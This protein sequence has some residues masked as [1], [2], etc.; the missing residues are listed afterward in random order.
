VK[1]R[2]KLDSNHC[3]IVKAYQ[4]LGCSVANTAKA[5][6]GVPDL[7]VGCMGLTDPVEIKTEDGRLLST[8]QEFIE[9]WR[10][11]PVVVVRTQ[12]DVIEH[13]TALRRRARA[14]TK[15]IGLERE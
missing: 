7:F 11:S 6:A 5:G 8:Q 2:I 9:G 12:D 14:G 13:V 1:Y 15:M 3:E 10:G 4:D